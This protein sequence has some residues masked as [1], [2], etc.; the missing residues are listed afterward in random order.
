MAGAGP[1]LGV[2]GPRS[3]DSC[4]E[5]TSD[6]MIPRLVPTIPT[7]A[8][9]VS[10]CLSCRSRGSYHVGSGM[11]LEAGRAI[12]E[13]SHGGSQ[14]VSSPYLADPVFR[15][16]SA[17]RRRISSV[18]IPLPGLQRARERS[19]IAKKSGLVLRERLSRSELSTGTSIATGR[20]RLMST[21]PSFLAFLA[22]SEREPDAP[23]SST[24]FTTLSPFH[25]LLRGRAP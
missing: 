4:V 12:R 10:L 19:M 20:P 23:D 3:F 9:Y 1:S 8:S 15:R 14:L 5:A 13:D 17:N 21:N 11:S 25:R 24:V 16:R 7:I 22:Y 2:S 6:A 18:E